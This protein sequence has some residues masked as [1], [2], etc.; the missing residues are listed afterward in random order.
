MD[1][2]ISIILLIF[3]VLYF[4][5]SLSLSI[6]SKTY[7]QIIILLLSFLS[8]VLLTIATFKGEKKI[9]NKN[10]KEKIITSRVFCVFIITLVYI[11][12]IEKIGFYIDTEIFLVG[13]IYF[14]G[15]RNLKIVFFVPLL[16]TFFLFIIFRLL[17]RIPTPIGILF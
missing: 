2:I 9:E 17:L 11:F 3:C 5:L 10:N 1:R 13:L 12:L 14:L 15:V 16:F 6:Q 7:P 8:I 4:Y